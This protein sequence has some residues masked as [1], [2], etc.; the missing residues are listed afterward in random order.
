MMGSGLP[1]QTQGSVTARDNPTSRNR[2]QQAEMSGLN[3]D[4]ES[5]TK[6]SPERQNSGASGSRHRSNHSSSYSH[7]VSARQ[8]SLY[9]LSY[10][11]G[12]KKN[13]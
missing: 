9:E 8:P 7:V 3:K 6:I 4:L 1:P 11:E 13:K 5:E 12:L 10:L 2:T